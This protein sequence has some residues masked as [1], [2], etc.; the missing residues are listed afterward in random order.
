MDPLNYLPV[1]VIL[2]GR[3]TLLAAEIVRV[4]LFLSCHALLG[5]EH[6]Y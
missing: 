5:S 2:S 1:P 4:Q 3:A 6:P